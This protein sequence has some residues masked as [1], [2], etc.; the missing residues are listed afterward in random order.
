MCDPRRFSSQLTTPPRQLR[1]LQRLDEP[2]PSRPDGCHAGR[3]RCDRRHQH[4][5]RPQ[6]Q[7]SHHP[8]GYRDMYDHRVAGLFMGII[9]SSRV[10]F[11]MSNHAVTHTRNTLPGN[12]IWQCPTCNGPY[13][14]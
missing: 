5:S 13:H 12:N 9:D 14:T 1:P 11:E 4:R 3:H 8:D 6:A 2:R 10:G 7:R